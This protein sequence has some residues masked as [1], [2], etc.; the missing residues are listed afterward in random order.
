MTANAHGAYFRLGSNPQTNE[1]L[2][3]GPSIVGLADPGHATAISLC[4][5]TT[6]LLATKPNLDGIVT[7]NILL[8]LVDEIGNA[9]LQAHQELE[10]P[11]NDTK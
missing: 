7:S 10:G 6:V 4:Q 2:L 1:V 3:A 8:K 11:A 9:L 5:I